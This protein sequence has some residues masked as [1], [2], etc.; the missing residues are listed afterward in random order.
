MSQ[1]N[2]PEYVMGFIRDRQTIAVLGGIWHDQKFDYAGG[3]NLIYRG[4]HEMHNIS[5]DD[6]NWEVW[7]YTYDIGNNVTRIQGPLRGSWTNRASL[8]FV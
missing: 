7:K 6:T 3:S 8:G 5:E 1:A 2:T 4:V